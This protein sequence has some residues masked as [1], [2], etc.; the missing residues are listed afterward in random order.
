MGCEM[1]L[2][3]KEIIWK[4]LSGSNI[5]LYEMQKVGNEFK[6]APKPYNHT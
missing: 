4:I 2:V 5:K 3:H 6:V 1:P